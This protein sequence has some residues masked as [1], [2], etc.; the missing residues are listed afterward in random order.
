MDSM[1]ASFSGGELDPSLYGRVDL[2]R[3]PISLRVCRNYIVQPH[4]G[5]KNR[6]GTRFVAETKDS[7]KRSRLIP[8]QF[9]TTDTCVL[10][11]GDSYFRVHHNGAPVTMSDDITPVEVATSITESMLPNMSVAQS[12]NALF[13]A[14]TTL[15]PQRIE[16]Y[17][18]REW[19]IFDGPAR[20]EYAT[21]LPDVRTNY[22]FK[23][24]PWLDI[25]TD[26]TRR[27]LVTSGVVGTTVTIEASKAMFTTD[28]VGQLLY[29]EDEGFGFPWEAGKSVASGLTVRSD[30][31]YYKSTGAGTTGTLR[32]SHDDGKWKD[33]VTGVEWE[34]LHYGFGVVKITGGISDSGKKATGIVVST[35]PDSIVGTA[36]AAATNKTMTNVVTLDIWPSWHLYFSAAHDFVAGDVM[37]FTINYTNSAGSPRTVTGSVKLEAPGIINATEIGML[38]WSGGDFSAFSSG[39]A[40]VTTATV[41]GNG[42]YLHA[43]GA[44]SKDNW[45][46]A[47]SFFQQRL[48]YGATPKEPQTLWMSR[49][50]AYD[51]FGRSNPIQP[52]DSI[53]FTL[54]S[55]QLNA[56]RSFAVMDKLLTLTAG[57][58]W[59]M[60]NGQEDAVTP[61]TIGARLQGYRGAAELP[62]LGIGNS[63]LFVQDKGQVVRDLAYEFTQDAYVS[64]DMT[65]MAS[66]LLKGY[67]IVDWAYQS[68]PFSVVW[69]V[70]N[71]GVLLGLT[72]MREQ[73]VVGWHRHDTDGE[74]ESVACVS[75]TDPYTGKVTD[76]LYCI[77][78]RTINGATKRYVERFADRQLDEFF[79]DC[80]TTVS[81]ASV[82]INDD[83]QLLNLSY[84]AAWIEGVK[85]QLYYPADS[86]N[87]TH[88]YLVSGTFVFDAGMVGDTFYWR[89][90]SGNIYN[91][92][93]TA[94]MS[95]S[96][97]RVTLGQ[98]TPASFIQEATGINWFMLAPITQWTWSNIAGLGGAGNVTIAAVVHEGSGHW[99]DP[100]YT[101][102]TITGSA[103][104]FVSGDIDKTVSIISG[105]VQ[106]DMVVA[107]NPE[108]GLAFAVQGT[109]PA[110]GV[111]TNWG[112]TSTSLAAAHLKAKSVWVVGA[113]TESTAT[114]NASTG[115]VLA[116][117]EASYDIG[118]PIV[119]DF[120]TLDVTAQEP[121][122]NKQKIIT[123][124]KFLIDESKTL[125]AGNSFTNLFPT[126]IDTVDDYDSNT[127]V[128]SG[129]GEVVIQ[130]QWSRNGR[131][132][133][134]HT[135]PRAMSILA[136]IP[137]VTL[138]S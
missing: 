59:L 16:R 94:L 72:Y 37:A 73:K 17:G 91:A 123:N 137:E 106:Y 63:V 134:R 52:D 130:S 23:L 24:G 78:K 56:I 117:T 87:T 100:S 138:G 62:P 95:G 90:A 86:T 81:Q 77:V 119:H 55:Q 10:E 131:V 83:V 44:W 40:N 35:V 32:P 70:R 58:V 21:D 48:C 103:Y 65:V 51:D 88:M 105:G 1:Q 82:W 9:N 50:D 43:L 124:V 102:Y 114:V 36:S 27:V 20:F 33:G 128:M 80:G 135:A 129:I 68:H 8:F 60:G 85:T 14:T 89:D 15:Q 19:R 53:T 126:N 74:F 22:P 57:G 127:G 12:A 110:V 13:T 107:A 11:F 122:R 84:G 42:T 79:V 76:A 69:M 61:A 67:E 38:F 2:D 97:V 30:G 108:G 75:E 26:K 136:V 92:T 39:T 133:V 66:H 121:L 99:S 101:Y 120:E 109:V 71:D 113:S 41:T 112:F 47:V 25:N 116:G 31:K 96:Y 5:L 125:F 6:T 46:G 118:L 34:F 45:P 18:A 98:F 29:L 4:G 111:Y 7:T 115:N 54:A 28:S 104:T 49:T 64:N 93:V 132:C 3:Y